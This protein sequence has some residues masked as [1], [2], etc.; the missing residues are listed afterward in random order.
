MDIRQPEYP[1]ILIL[2]YRDGYAT[3]RQ[4]AFESVDDFEHWAKRRPYSNE[5][6][7]VLVAIDREPAVLFNGV[8]LLAVKLV[9]GFL[10]AQDAS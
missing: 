9:R 3:C 4:Y 8:G 7:R 2:V 5:G 1:H 10:E 6:L